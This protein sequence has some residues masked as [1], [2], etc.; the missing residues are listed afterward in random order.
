MTTKTNQ[1]SPSTPKSIPHT[2]QDAFFDVLKVFWKSGYSYG[3]T[4]RNEDFYARVMD[5]FMNLSL[6]DFRIKYEH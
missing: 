2:F 1:P 6:E 3:V 4:G 5:D